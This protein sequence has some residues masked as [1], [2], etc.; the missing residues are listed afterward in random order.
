MST[1]VVQWVGDH[2]EQIFGASGIGSAVLAFA[3]TRKI[4]ATSDARVQNALADALGG[5]RKD[6]DTSRQMAS[7]AL[8]M[9]RKCE[10]ARD[11]ERAERD[12]ERERERKAREAEREECSGRIDALR[13]ELEQLRSE[14]LSQHSP[15]RGG[16]A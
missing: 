13:G 6:L 4:K 7:E 3:Q 11:E 12:D 10:G 5:M 2:W 9:A 1:D 8:D 16:G 14:V 15:P